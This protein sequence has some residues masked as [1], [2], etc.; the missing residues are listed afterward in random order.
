MDMDL[1]EEG[2]H[3]VFLGVPFVL[4]ILRKLLHRGYGRG[5]GSGCTGD[6]GRVGWVGVIHAVVVTVTTLI[7]GTLIIG[8]LTMGVGGAGGLVRWG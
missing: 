8:T 4:P 6:D 3:F 1:P 7:I 5:I 2:D